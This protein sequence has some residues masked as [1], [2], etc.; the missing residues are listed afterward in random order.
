[1]DALLESMP[2]RE[3]KTYDLGETIRLELEKTVSATMD[4]QTDEILGE[5]NRRNG[6]WEH[7]LLS[8]K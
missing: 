3:D 5:G 2:I 6:Y 7:T 4:A 1:M 8:R